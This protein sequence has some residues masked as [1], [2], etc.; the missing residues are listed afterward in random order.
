MVLFG[1]LL[2]VAVLLNMLNISTVY[3]CT[4]LWQYAVKIRKLARRD[5]FVVPDDGIKMATCIVIIELY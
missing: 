1:T 5:D 4:D 2:D 3:W